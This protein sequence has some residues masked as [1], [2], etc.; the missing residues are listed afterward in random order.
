MDP[1]KVSIESSWREALEE[2]FKKPYFDEIKAYLQNEIEQGHTVYPPGP[3]IFRAFELT[4]ID[5]VK[6]VIIGQDPYH[7]PGEA[8]GLCFSVPQ[9]IRVPPSLRNVYKE[10]S[11]DTGFVIPDHGDL[12]SW[13]EQGIF[14]LNAMLTVRHKSAGS[15]KAI[16]WQQFTDAVIKTISDKKEGIIFLLWGKFAQSKLPLINQL[17]HHVLI[18][19]HPSPLARNAFFNCKHFSKTNE[20]LDKMGSE[21]INWQL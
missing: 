12:T 1:S 6:V 20:L 2:E 15:H 21:S 17:K 8:M 19:A 14:L 10:L 7:N 18:A 5:K 9:G 13:G 11:T 16:G 4:P 3:K